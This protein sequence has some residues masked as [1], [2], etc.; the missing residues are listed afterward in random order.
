MSASLTP[1]ASAVPVLQR[2]LV[3]LLVLLLFVF[4]LSV[5]LR[6]LGQVK[7]DQDEGLQTVVVPLGATELPA[8]V[9]P[10]PASTAVEAEPSV[11]RPD[12]L[13][14]VEEP[15][16]TAPLPPP[17]PT[18]TV[19]SPPK[20]AASR[21]PSAAS[22]PKPA[23]AAR[24]YVVL[25]TFSDAGN[26]KALVMRVRQ[27][28]FRAEAVPMRTGAGTLSRVRAGPF[29]NEAE[30]QGARASLIVEGMTGAKLVKEP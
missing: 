29:R 21:V 27:S 10:E 14:A 22:P 13:A 11:P 28:G 15:A 25:G 18:P 20:P 7:T 8:A 30:G 19:I 26:A 23:L 2:R 5:L 3:G 12:P 1:E 9:A 17:T 4:L 24:W 6:G 16:P